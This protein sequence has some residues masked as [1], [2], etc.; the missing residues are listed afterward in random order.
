[1]KKAVERAGPRWSGKEAIARA[2]AAVGVCAV[3]GC[4]SSPP[5][6]YYTLSTVP[7]ASRLTVPSDAIPIRLDRVTI[8]GELDRLDLV[9]RVDSNRIQIAEQD[10][11]AAPL[12]EMIR[13]VLSEDLASSLPPQWVVSPN[14]PSV[15]ER[16]QSVAVDVQEFYAD[17]TCAVT[18]R[19]S[20]TVRSPDNKHTSQGAASVQAPA[21]AE[22][23]G[24]AGIPAAMS[25][26][27]S[28]FADRMART[29][30]GG[31]RVDANALH[32]TR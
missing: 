23:S 5:M 13:R 1:M 12:D 32:E 8:P 31:G 7:A 19:A 22:C 11:W 29:I 18:L 3:I 14:E 6:H 10:R 2:S 30:A 26:A 28:Q 17:A 21:S 16:R 9:R 25:Q 4:A 20:W 27:L 15:G 24:N